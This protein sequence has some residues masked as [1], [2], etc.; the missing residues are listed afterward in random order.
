MITVVIVDDQDLVREGISRMLK[1]Q[2]EIDV[3][4]EG[5]TGED[6]LRLVRE[7]TPDVILMDISMPGI[8]GLE[9]TRKL[10]KISP[11]LKVLALSSHSGEIYPEKLLNA[12]ASG[13]ITKGVESS[14]V[15]TAIQEVHA[16]K[17]YL[18]QEIAQQLALSSL[19]PYKDKSP[20]SLLSE[21]ELQIAIMVTRGEEVKEIAEQLSISPKTVNSYRYRVFEKL[22]V[23]NDVQLTHIALLH[24]LINVNGMPEM[25]ENPA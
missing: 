8:G 21:R 6:A 18:T 3:I 23:K 10:H 5:K 16:G 20:F 24:N 2:S 12:G 14:E 17:R 25:N 11:N 7:F 22:Y 15:I 19:L 9:A 13:Y 1:D 4:G